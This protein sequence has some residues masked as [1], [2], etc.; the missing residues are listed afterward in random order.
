M[1]SPSPQAVFTYWMTSNCFSLAQVGLL[2]HPLVR[3]KL[4]I[5]ERIEHPTSAL[6][7]NDGF[8]ETIRKGGCGGTDGDVSWSHLSKYDSLS[9]LDFL[10]SSFSASI[11]RSLFLPLHFFS[12]SLRHIFSSFPTFLKHGYPSLL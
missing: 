3:Q 2:K 4:R 1:S 9:G 7:Q 11:F 12:L 6:P 8:I 10:F 5:P